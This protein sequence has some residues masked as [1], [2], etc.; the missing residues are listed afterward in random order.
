MI[1]VYVP[2]GAGN[3]DVLSGVEA[4]VQGGEVTFVLQPFPCCA[5]GCFIVHQAPVRQDQAVADLVHGPISACE[6]TEP[7]GMMTSA[8]P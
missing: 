7:A 5:E 4:G 6:S 3:D 1:C 8:P 2:V